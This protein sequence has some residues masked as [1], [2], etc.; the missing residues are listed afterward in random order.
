MDV[1]YIILFILYLKYLF[2]EVTIKIQDNLDL[3]FSVI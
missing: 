1:H 2:K 3:N